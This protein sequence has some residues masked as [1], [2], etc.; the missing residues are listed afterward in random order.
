VS[1]TFVLAPYT[2]NFAENG[3]P[4]GT[5]FQVDL[6]GPYPVNRS[7]ISTVPF[8]VPDGTYPYAVPAVSGYTSI[9]SVGNVTVAGTNVSVSITFAPVGGGETYPVTFTEAGLPNGTGWTVDLGGLDHTSTGDSISFAEPNGSY[10]FAISSADQWTPDPSEGS[11]L[12]A[13]TAFYTGVLFGPAPAATSYPLTFTESGLSS[14]T[15]WS[16]SLTGAANATNASTSQTVAFWETNGTYQITIPDAAGEM[17]NATS[18]VTV[19]GA[20]VFVNVS[21]VPIR[22]VVSIVE[23]GLPAAAIW[24]VKMYNSSGGVPASAASTETEIDF[25][26]P[27][28][29]Y[30]LA[31]IGPAGYHVTLSQTAVNISGANPAAITA[32]F[33]INPPSG[34]AAASLPLS[35]IGMVLAV[36]LGGGLVVGWAGRRYAVRRWRLEANRWIQDIHKEDIGATSRPPR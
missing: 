29:S 13:G 12:I 6:G 1:V 31:V 17:A 7:G 14:G 4:S 23:T 30:N 20:P 36:S 2:I 9:P 33:T 16:V 5:Y 19:A 11:L 18:R 8:S 32:A 15:S 21:F 24:A 10:S 28:G 34:S 25:L 27:N 3:L 35:T 26:L 22:Y